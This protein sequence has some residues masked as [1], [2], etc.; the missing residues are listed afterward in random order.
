MRIP[1]FLIISFLTLSTTVQA[2]KK[3]SINAGLPQKLQAAVNRLQL[4]SQCS[5]ASISLTVL[6]AE[7][8]APV[9]TYHPDMGLAPASTLKTVTSITAYNLLGADFKFQTRFGYTGTIDANGVLNGDVIIKGG[10]DPTLGSW[11][12]NDTK[13]NS[14]LTKLVTALQQAGIKKINGRIIGDDSVFDTQ[15]IPDGW[16]WQDTGNYYGAGAS[17]LCW[18]EN[19]FDIKYETGAVGGPVKILRTSP[20]MPYF[21]FKS[22]VSTS[23]SGTGD[24]SYAYLPVGNKQMYIRGAYA[25]DK[26]KKSISVA[27]PD[28][29]YDAAWR[30]TDTLRHLGI[31]VSKEPESTITFNSKTEVIPPIAKELTTITSPD[32]NQIIYWLN[33]ESINLYAEQLLKTIALKSGK[34]V[35]TKTGVEVLKSFWKENGIDSRSLNLYDGSGL[36][37]GD[38]ITSRSLARILLTAVN[39]PWFSPFYES[40]PLYNNMHMKSGTIAD[41]VAYAGYQT[42]NGR[43]L[44][45]SVMINNYNGSTTTMRQKLF[46]VLDELK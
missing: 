21:N 36:S 43:K 1:Y 6:D 16:I 2:Q 8:G 15:S 38:R 5:Y 18:R 24:K 25:I 45:F 20:A 22:E 26:A 30:L 32:F 40:L 35:S 42:H 39:Q 44:C 11:R 19:T 28:P 33:R 31:T 34:E 37:P 27:L 3:V 12:W 17:G 9:F 41:V 7:T 14:I 23:G 10:G 29:A 46:K 13:E 4:D